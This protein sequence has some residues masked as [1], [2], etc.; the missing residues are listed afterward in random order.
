[1][2][3]SRMQA[4]SFI[5]HKQKR[6]QHVSFRMNLCFPFSRRFVGL[7]GIAL[8]PVCVLADIL[9]LI[10]CVHAIDNV[11]IQFSIF[12]FLFFIS[13]QAVVLQPTV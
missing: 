4:H 7:F 6:I 3:E 10:M 5:M 13:I 12:L 9:K 11:N 2:N 8:L 1:M